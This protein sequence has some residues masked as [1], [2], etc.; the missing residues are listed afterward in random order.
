AF[1][2]RL[3]APNQ[4]TPQTRTRSS[5]RPRG[6]AVR[7]GP[8][9]TPVVA[10]TLVVAARARRRARTTR[11]I[12]VS[13]TLPTATRPRVRGP[14][15][16]SWPTARIATKAEAQSSTVTVMAAA[17]RRP[18]RRVVALGPVARGAVA[19]GPVAGAVAAVLLVVMYRW[20]TER[21]FSTSPDIYRIIQYRCIVHGMLDVHRLR[22]FRSVV[23]SGSVA[24]A[25]ANLGYTPSAVSQHVS[26]LQ[27]ETGLQLVARHGRGVRPTAAGEALAAQADG[28][29][30]RLGE[31][32]S[33]IADL[34]S[35][36]T[37]RLSIAYFASVGA[38]WL[39]RVVSTLT[40]RFPGLR[41]ELELRE[42]VPTDA[43]QR[44]DLQ[45]AVAR[46][47][48]EPGQGFTAHHLLDDPYVA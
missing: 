16:T 47:G 35:G 5:T 11:S 44:A 43:A 42:D 36:R 21:R 39:P 28:V 17:V 3:Y 25:A 30:A 32:E 12:A 29:L 45:V 48:Y 6:A 18:A 33:F 8:A 26:A 7:P 14:G 40:D 24:A 38:A 2:V 13:A 41:L 19:R 4:A 20:W 23:A 31:A 46:R 15:S 37:G 27:R 34:R 9:G 22:I 1:S 10:G